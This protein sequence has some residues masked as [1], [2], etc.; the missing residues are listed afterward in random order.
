MAAKNPSNRGLGKTQKPAGKA[1]GNGKKSTTS[2]LKGAVTRVGKAATK[3]NSGIGWLSNAAWLYSIYVATAQADPN[4]PI[5]QQILKHMGLQFL[6]TSMPLREQATK[7][8][9]GIENISAAQELLKIIES[10]G[11]AAKAL[12]MRSDAIVK[13]IDELSSAEARSLKS[14]LQEAVLSIL[15]EASGNLTAAVVSAIEYQILQHIIPLKSGA[16]ASKPKL[17]L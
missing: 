4:H 5:L 12:G 17:R 15:R 14:E 11:S 2:A 9:I 8:P 6:Q 3:I 10:Y 16:K 1:S 7:S 13:A